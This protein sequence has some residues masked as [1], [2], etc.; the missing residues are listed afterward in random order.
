MTSSLSVGGEH[1]RHV[2]EAF[3]IEIG[4]EDSQDPD[5]RPAHLRP[6]VPDKREDLRRSRGR[7][8]ELVFESLERL[9][10]DV[11]LIGRVQARLRGLLARGRRLVRRRAKPEA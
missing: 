7:V 3:F 11:L 6:L 1:P 5:G 10:E 4:L 8:R 9:D 2:G